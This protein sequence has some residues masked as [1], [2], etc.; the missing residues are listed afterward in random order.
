VWLLCR[1]L[2]WLLARKCSRLG[3]YRGRNRSAPTFGCAVWVGRLRFGFGFALLRPCSSGGLLSFVVT[4]TKAL[5]P[6]AC[7]TLSKP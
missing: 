2:G 1:L 5:W 7:R 3:N 4:P 6:N